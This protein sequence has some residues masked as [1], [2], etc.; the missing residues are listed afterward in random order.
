MGREKKRAKAVV[1]AAAQLEKLQQKELEEQLA[2]EAQRERNRKR[3]EGPGGQSKRRRIEIAESDMEDVEDG[4]GPSTRPRKSRNLSLPEMVVDDEGAEERFEDEEVVIPPEEPVAG[5]S[6]PNIDNPTLP[7][8]PDDGDVLMQE[9]EEDDVEFEYGIK[10]Q[11]SR[12]DRDMDKKER[13]ENQWITKIEPQLP[14]AFYDNHMDPWAG[15]NEDQVHA[16]LTTNPFI[17]F[18]AVAGRR[19]NDRKKMLITEAVKMLL[20]RTDVTVMSL[21]KDNPW[22]VVGLKSKEEIECLI[23]QGAVLNRYH[24]TLVVF[25]ALR[26]TAYQ[27]RCLTVLRA[28]ADLEPHIQKALAEHL[29]TS[30]VIKVRRRAMIKETPQT[31]VLCII[32]VPKEE[33]K[34]FQIPSQLKFKV[35]QSGPAGSWEV[36]RAPGCSICLSMDHFD[37]EC[38]WHS[39]IRD[40]KQIRLD[41]GEDRRKNVD[42]GNKGEATPENTI[43]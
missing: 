32:K 8:N 21:R 26:K 25:R 6:V 27:I 16:T 7:T 20:D 3:M 13:Q 24:R 39:V 14:N 5:P 9:E 10:I 37:N 15:L 1:D 40:F 4:P 19:G 11:P 28:A 18:A 12:Y 35:S 43:Q 2:K 29:K 38:L 34:T 33:A 36:K 30:A 41:H 22:V 42:T 31:E 17:V 23:K